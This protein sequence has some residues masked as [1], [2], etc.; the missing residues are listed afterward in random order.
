MSLIQ[1]LNNL[2]FV[3]ENKKKVLN[4][5]LLRWAILLFLIPCVVL[6]LFSEKKQNTVREKIN[7]D[8]D[9]SQANR[10]H[11]ESLKGSGGRRIDNYK[12][13][14]RRDKSA[15][16]SS[17]GISLA[18]PEFISRP[19]SSKI[20]PGTVVKAI[21]ENGATDG[22]I[23]ARLLE[24]VTVM[25]NVVFENE[26][27]LIGIAESQDNRL[28]IRFYHLKN[29]K[30]EVFEIRSIALDSQDQTLGLAASQF[31]NESIKLGASIGL[32]FVSGLSEGLK[33]KTNLN[34]TVTDTNSSR[35]AFLNGTEKASLEYSRDLMNEV[36]NK[37]RHLFV[38]KGT[39]ILVFF[40]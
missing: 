7:I 16:R 28:N 12:A 26:S 25:G 36:K 14:L 34:G 30:D 39:E 9:S 18:G 29:P 10:I 40:D 32:N 13:D 20:P 33:E 37:K 2:L 4:K 15:S 8:V 38:E 24:D 31:G 6:V 19:G 27:V 3:D 5:K 1:K 23:K 21:L 35:N 22:P 11:P 17:S